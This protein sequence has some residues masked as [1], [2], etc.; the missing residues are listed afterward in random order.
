MVESWFYYF[1]I[2]LNLG[3]DFGVFIWVVYVDIFGII[4]GVYV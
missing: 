2:D 1:K 4:I 3:Y